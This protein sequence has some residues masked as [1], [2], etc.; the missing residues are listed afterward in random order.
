[1]LLTYVKRKVIK[2]R[3]ASY[4]LGRFRHYISRLVHY[5]KVCFIDSRVVRSCF[6]E[7]VLPYVKSCDASH[8]H[9]DSAAWRSS[10]LV[11]ARLIANKLGMSVV[12]YQGSITDCD[13]GVQVVR[14]YHWVKDV[15]VPPASFTPSHRDLLVLV[16][17]DYYCDMPRLLV[18]WNSVV[19]LY[20]FQPSKAAGEFSEFYFTFNNQNMVE[21]SVKGGQKYTHMIW[22]YSCDV[23]LVTDGF[24]SKAYAIDRRA[25]NDEHEYV[26]LVPIGKW[27]GVFS[28]F[29]QMLECDVLRR[30]QVVDGNF[31][32]L[33]THGE[34]GAVRS[35]SKL[36]SLNAINLSKSLFEAVDSA[37]RNSSV[38]PGFAMVQSWLENDR[39]GAATLL[40]YFRQGFNFKPMVVYPAIQGIRSYQMI[41]KFSDYDPEAKN[42]MISFMSPLLPVAFVP[43]RTKLNE[44][45]SIDRRILAPNEDARS[46]VDQAP[47]KF[48]VLEMEMFV[49]LLLPI[50]GILYPH[51]M[52]V[53]YERQSRPNQR[54]LLDQYEFGVR[55][56]DCVTFMKAEPYLK[57]NDP[58]MITT[59]QTVIKRDYSRYTYALSDYI[60]IL[61][62]Y[63]FGKNP[64]DIAEYI[65]AMCATSKI[66][67]LCA[68]AVRMDGHV[69]DVVR[70]LERMI[71]LRAFP[72]EL[73]EEIIQLHGMQ[74]NVDA[75][76]QCRI[77]YRIS[78]Q[79]GSGSPETA[80]FNTILSKFMDYYARRLA[81]IPKDEAFNSLGQFGGDDSIVSAF[82]GPICVDWLNKAG[83]AVGQRL[84]TQWFQPGAVGVNYLSRYFSELVWSGDSSSMC[85]LPRALS[86]LH[87][88]VNITGLT[89]LEKLQ[90]KLAGLALS[91]PHTP[92]I[93]IILHAANRLGMRLDIPVRPDV[94]G[95]WAQYG[96]EN[97]WP[98]RRVD[99]DH[100]CIMSFLPTADVDPLYDYLLACNSASDLLTMPIIVAIDNLPPKST[101]PITVVD[102]TIL[103]KQVN[104]VCK[105]FLRGLCKQGDKCRYQHKQVCKFYVDGNCKRG[106]Q[107]RFPH[108]K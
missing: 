106:K 69:H 53:V 62:W 88:T 30:L 54:A 10:A 21:Y 34:D 31:A 38:K 108:V 61:S 84:E 3:F 16:D 9:P 39:K 94:V 85:D 18:E 55:E 76:T 32:V 25:A 73:S 80:L 6:R 79:R 7:T 15:V 95:W 44:Q 82:V 26:L 17:V 83:S 78:S 77:K 103:V 29:A 4:I 52:D 72:K 96:R 12:S 45:A 105:R 75:K 40:D 81:G 63:S 64:R 74:F 57:P 67:V 41:N 87:V 22:N 104:G 14:D 19:L 5:G 20:T 65:A 60:M 101:A 33:D 100:A 42:L 90:Q 98:N 23:I 35:I 43:D 47:S 24:V 70:T 1:M 13:E 71:L 11:F 93:R 50:S 91:D 102:D 59:F 8:I 51:E 99:D 107:C 68:D 58:R 92:I 66:G 46:L 28:W 37:Y 89:P 49:K 86:K 36:G 27:R 56:P 2:V 97:N 48:L